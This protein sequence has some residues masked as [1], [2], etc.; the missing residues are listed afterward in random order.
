MSKNHLWLRATGGLTWDKR[1]DGHLRP[2][3]GRRLTSNTA[4]EISDAGADRG[5]PG[6]RRQGGTHILQRNAFR[7][8]LNRPVVDGTM[9]SVS[10]QW[11]L[12]TMSEIDLRVRSR[13]LWKKGDYREIL[14]S[15]APSGEIGLEKRGF[16]GGTG[17]TLR[18]DVAQDGLFEP[19]LKKR[20]VNWG[21]TSG[22][23]THKLARKQCMEN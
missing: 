21:P 19:R 9:G 20:S 1:H 6:L 22:V 12:Q 15:H 7:A 23:P 3:G 8:L 4:K 10:R 18:R 2:F 13:S 16:L 17:Q 5:Q 11:V 14:F